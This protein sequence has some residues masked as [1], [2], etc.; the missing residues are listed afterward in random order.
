M[1]PHQVGLIGLGLLGTALAER[2]LSGGL[3]VTGF[4]LEPV[5]RENLSRLSGAAV[6]SAGEVAAACEELVLCLPDSRVVG[7]VVAALSGVLRPGMLLLDATTGDPQDAVALAAELATGG[8]GYVDATVAGSSE[9]VRR[10]EAVILCGGTDFDLNRAKLILATWSGQRHHVGPAGSG[11]KLKLIVNLVLGLN[12]AVLAE[13]LALAEAC[14]LDL[15]ATLGVLKATPAY[16]RIMDSKGE[17]M[18]TRDYHPQARL[19]QHLKDVRLILDLA[20]QSDA[21]A[22]LSAL[23]QDLLQ[24]AIVRGLA[25][26]DNSAIME[27]FRQR[28]RGEE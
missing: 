26:E 6:A 15:P 27:V 13:A 28:P 9:Q 14:G 10:G 4:D 12:R 1:P 18:I 7:Q 16:S 17:K 11:A 8:I 5:R 24:E 23:H 22:P 19:A 3:D 2:M 21:R 25:D 20:R